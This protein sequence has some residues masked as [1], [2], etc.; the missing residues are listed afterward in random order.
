MEEQRE[1]KAS[2]FWN[3]STALKPETH[4]HKLLKSYYMNMCRKLVRNTIQIPKEKFASTQMCS[5]CG[6]FWSESEFRMK[7]KS[8]HVTV[9]GKTKRLIEK[10]Q[11]SKEPDQKDLLTGKQRKRA[12]WLQKRATQHIEIKCDQCQHK[13]IVKLDKPKKKAKKV[14]DV[15][16]VQQEAI[17]LD[18]NG[19]KSKPKKK[20]KNKDKVAGLKIP[21][22]KQQEK[23][24]QQQN[25][26][27]PKTPQKEK[28]PTMTSPCP[29][30]T[31][32]TPKV[33]QQL[34]QTNKTKKKKKPSNATTTPKASNNNS[35]KVQ[36]VVSKTQQQNSLLQLAALLKNNSSNSGKNSTQNRLEALLK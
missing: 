12:K 29:A 20:K 19:P 32:Q 4:V 1:S 15:A 26:N 14:D 22:D 34:T 35:N 17:A 31:A 21:L 27:K 25:T 30:P 8:Q 10:L 13:S 16:D 9:K 2:L 33:A 5:H 7:L 6:L 23:P 28:P 36:K 11:K 24:L 18:E 3:C